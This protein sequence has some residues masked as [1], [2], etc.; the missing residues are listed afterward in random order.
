MRLPA[1]ILPALYGAQIAA[2]GKNSG[3]L[4][5]KFDEAEQLA[6]VDGLREGREGTRRQGLSA[7]PSRHYLGYA[8]TEVGMG[9]W[10]RVDPALHLVGVEAA[11][12][13]AATRLDAFRE[14][15]LG[16]DWVNP[17]RHAYTLA[18][19]VTRFS[20]QAAPHFAAWRLEAEQ[21]SAEMVPI[22]V[23][24]EEPDLLS[25]LSGVWPLE[26]LA[27]KKL[28][29]IGAGSIGSAAAEAL[30]A[31]G[32]RQLVLVDPDRLHS[33]NF[34]RHRV[35]PINLG[36]YK[37]KALADRLGE[38]DPGIE[39]EALTLDVIYDADVIRPLMGEADGVLVSSDG[40]DSRRAAN[41]LARRA[42]RPAV[43]ACVL[44]NGGFGEVLRIRP[45]RTGCL[46]CA[47]AELL[48]SGA[49]N[50]EPSLDRGY[51][52]GTRHLPMTA[53]GGDLG[54][55]GQLA[56]KASV[57]TL[58]AD[59][60]YRE[61]RLPGDHAILGLQP[62]PNVA[63]PFDLERAGELRWR[64]LPPPRPDCPTCGSG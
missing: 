43:F 11:R 58:L 3:S 46:L 48:Q 37:V 34:A 4:D 10:F 60:G 52:E 14:K 50:P 39:V 25:P 35:D 51:G 63:A 54:L 2:S 9:L 20:E 29:L 19:T 15:V 31:Y 18:V 24:A 61:Q 53:V 59:L 56:A 16:G 27:D 6:L 62:K 44:A 55:V 26:E 38:R 22:D 5:I 36:R 45:P 42:V 49:M 12:H 64:D 47:R 32:I 21:G 1:L 57:A 40:V 41:H 13:G 28:V 30:A 8:T 17:G 7:V 33:D 23:V